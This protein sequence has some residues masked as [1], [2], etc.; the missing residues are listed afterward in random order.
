M[1][2]S[3]LNALLQLFAMI[4]NIGKEG[5]STRATEI[6]HF[7]LQQHLSAQLITSYITLFEKYIHTFHPQL[8]SESAELPP[9]KDPLDKENIISICAQI[10][11]NLRQREKFIVFMRLVEFINEDEVMTQR[12]LDFVKMVADCFNITETEHRNTIAYILDTLSG[13]MQKDKLLTISSESVSPIEGVRHLQKNDL[14][15][16][17][18]ILHHGSTNTLIFRYL[19]NH[20]LNLNGHYIPPDRIHL[21]EQGSLIT[22]PKITPVYYS[23]VISCFFRSEDHS[24]IVF[25]A[26]DIEFRFRKS[27]NGIQRFSFTKESGN[28]IGILGG[29]GVGKSTLLNILNG[30]LKPQE[31]QILINGYDLYSEKEKLEGVIGFVPQDDLLMEELSVFKNLYYNARLCFSGSTNEEILKRITRILNDLELNDIRDLKVGTPLNKFISGGQRKRLNIALELIREPSILFVD[32]PTSGLSSLDSEKVM[33]LLKEQTLKGK[34]VIVNIHQPYSDIFKLFDRI[35]I[36]DKG[37]FVIYRGNPIDALTYFKTA[38]NYVNAEEGQCISCGNVVPEQILQ[39]VEAKEVDEYGK[40]VDKRKVTPKEWYELYRKNFGT[41]PPDKPA[42]TDLPERMLNIPGPWEQFRIFSLRNI[43]SKLANRQYMLINFL[44]AP[45]L[46]LIIGYFTKYISDVTAN[47]SYIFRDNENLPVYIFIAVVVAL[48]MGLNVSAGEIIRDRKILKRESFLHLS[49]FCYLHSK[50]LILFLI[51]AIQ[52]FSFVIIG[53]TILEIQSMTFSYWVILF[54]ASCMAN[55]IGLN[56]S[57]GLNSMVAI[58]IIIPFFIVP[59]LL[60]SGVIVPFDKLHKVFRNPTY[61]P[62]IGELMTSRWA[63]E[64]IAVEQ[65]KNNRVERNYFKYDQEKGNAAFAAGEVIPQLIARLD[66]AY[67]HRNDNQVKEQ[68]AKSLGLVYNELNNF[69][70]DPEVPPFEKAD[71]LIDGNFTTAL[72]NETKNY[73]YSV[74]ALFQEKQRFANRNRE[75]KHSE[76]IAALGGKEAYE[77]LEEDY[78]NNK[79]AEQLLNK[80]QLRAF[81]EVNDQLVRKRSP[82]YME[83]LSKTGRAHFYAPVKFLGNLEMDTFWFNTI[84]IWITSLIFYIAL[85]YDLLRKVIVWTENVKLRKQE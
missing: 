77:K 59:N 66:E 21:L 56:L 2:E 63:Y 15:G 35:L 22:S 38:S 11:K 83:P 47:G 57:S 44:E 50:I 54:S 82:V 53:N 49:R 72:Y 45:V 28:L 16:M 68:Y 18:V 39:I 33:L 25:S 76:M 81:V 73:L 23:D 70:T 67:I 42:K 69:Q 24:K 71:S 80:T 30:S 26:R 84:V 48:F 7:Y 75:K 8:V 51:S 41:D 4:A 52:T 60:F 61:V 29:S 13:D 31:G 43:L 14:D 55:M 10:N 5:L 79:L 20:N 27:E 58:Y 17:I 32:E 40:L 78:L 37:G 6:V 1:N 64:A 9:G 62:F 74:K 12:E 19:G 65:F 85:S 36:L 46:A 3:I 34:L